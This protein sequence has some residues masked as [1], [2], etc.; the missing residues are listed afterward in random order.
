MF[1][2][3]DIFLKGLY[4]SGATYFQGFGAV[5]AGGLIFKIFD[6]TTTEQEKTYY[7][8]GVVMTII[9]FVLLHLR[10]KKADSTQV[11]KK[12]Q[13]NFNENT[14]ITQKASRGMSSEQEANNNKGSVIN[15]E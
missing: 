13:A 15:Q 11:Q 1:K 6:K 14:S 4:E 5:I 9:L 2:G 12:Q 7:W 3:L 10:Y 8:I